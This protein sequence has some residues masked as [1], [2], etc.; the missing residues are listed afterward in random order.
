MQSIEAHFS[1]ANCLRIQEKARQFFLAR[2]ITIRSK[3]IPPST[4]PGIVLLN[5]PTSYDTMLIR[6]IRPSWLPVV[7]Y[8]G[9]RLVRLSLTGLEESWSGAVDRGL[10]EHISR[11][12]RR[13]ITAYPGEMRSRT[14]SSIVSELEKNQMVK[15]SPEGRASK[16]AAIPSPEELHMGA[17]YRSLQKVPP[18][19]R[20]V[21]CGFIALEQSMITPAGKIANDSEVYIRFAKKPLDLSGIDFSSQTSVELPKVI[22]AQWEQLQSG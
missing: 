9:L 7:Y 20:N 3:N 4:G 15:I 14:Y 2:K 5:H 19:S 12:A 11:H 16:S 6:T 22:V 13:F 17:L 21:W 10:N 1:A 8:S 18:A